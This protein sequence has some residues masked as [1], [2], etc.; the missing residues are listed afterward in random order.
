[1]EIV[2]FFYDLLLE[3]DETDLHT[4][5]TDGYSTTH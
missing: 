1:M 5:P 4:F 2:A 3:T